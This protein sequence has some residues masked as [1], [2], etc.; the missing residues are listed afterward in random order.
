MKIDSNNID[1]D[2]VKRYMKLNPEFV[3][4]RVV[5]SAV[6]VPFGQ[7]MLDF[8]GMLSL[9]VVGAFL[10]ERLAE[11]ATLET[12]VD[13][14]VERFDVERETATRDVGAFLAQLRSN[15]ALVE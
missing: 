8:N 7:K 4:R 10:A 3:L 15:G 9:N 13:A 5:N 12:L 1:I 2:K 6:L 14:V 11:D